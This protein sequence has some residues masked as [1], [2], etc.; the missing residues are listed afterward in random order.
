MKKIVCFA[1]LLGNSAIVESATLQDMEAINNSY[2]P[3]SI[4]VC[5]KKGTDADSQK[6]TTLIR[7]KVLNRKS[8]HSTYQIT[9]ETYHSSDESP[10]LIARYQQMERLESKEQ[11]IYR[12]PET[13]K[14]TMPGHPEKEADM[15]RYFLAQIKPEGLHES[16][17]RFEI[18]KLP[19]YIVHTEDGA[20]IFCHK[21]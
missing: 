20:D 19:S 16:F 10:I 17:D 15:T 14:V 13:L 9:M 5:E 8:N 2:P 4:V 7:G 21:G 11:V 3:G 18:T 1:F 6:T 12:L